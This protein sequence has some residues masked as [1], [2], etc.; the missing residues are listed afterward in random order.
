MD[1]QLDRTLSIAVKQKDGKSK[2]T[3]LNVYVRATN[4]FNQ[5][6][7]INLYRGTGSW[8]DD[9]YLASEDQQYAIKQAALYGEQS[10]RD[11][12][13]MRMQNG[14]NISAPRTIRLGLKFDF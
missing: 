6:N 10:Y 13:T 1:L 2:V 8:N 9:G 3:F 4:L 5:F 7:I 12:Y 14:Y 11:Y